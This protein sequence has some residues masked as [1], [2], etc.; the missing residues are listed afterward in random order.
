MEENL[1]SKNEKK[2]IEL[3][4]SSLKKDYQEMN[5]VNAA[6]IGHKYKKIV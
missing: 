3:E 5:K 4:L 6:L 1:N 2:A